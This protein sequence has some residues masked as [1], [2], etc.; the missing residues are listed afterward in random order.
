MWELKDSIQSSL[1]SHVGGGERACVCVWGGDPS[2]EY[3]LMVEACVQRRNSGGT[4]M[5]VF[6]EFGQ[7]F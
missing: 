3:P 5:E 7:P 2:D 1:K 4:Q 6:C